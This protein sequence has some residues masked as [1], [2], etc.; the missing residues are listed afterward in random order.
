MVLQYIVAVQLWV[1]AAGWWCVLLL[2]RR[3]RPVWSMLQGPML[4]HSGERYDY[5]PIGMQQPGSVMITTY[6]HA[7]TRYTE[8]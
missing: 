6:M 8:F 5:L 1:H 3:S 2:R 4:P 7:P